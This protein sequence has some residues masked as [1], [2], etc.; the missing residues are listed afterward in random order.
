MGR[1]T[2]GEPRQLSGWS[3]LL[4]QVRR[5]VVVLLAA[6]MVAGPVIGEVVEAVGVAV[7]LV[8]NTIVGFATDLRVVRSMEALRHLTAT[9]A[10]VEREDRR[11]EIDSV[12]H[13]PGDTVSVERG[14]SPGEP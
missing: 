10:D 8:V 5:A 1:T 13:V 6:A 7:V 12:E 9:L 14:R 4:D 3:V 2:L 11:D